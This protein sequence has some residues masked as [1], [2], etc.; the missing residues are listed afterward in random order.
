MRQKIK[1]FYF[2]L[3]KD[4]KEKEYKNKI[5]IKINISKS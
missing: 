4:D 3:Q 1:P 2:I 5:K